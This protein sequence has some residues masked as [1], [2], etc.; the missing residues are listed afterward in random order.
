[1]ADIGTTF[2]A[3]FTDPVS[4][5]IG[6]TPAQP[7]SVPE[8]SPKIDVKTSPAPVAEPSP[9]FK[10]NQISEDAK[11]GIS[12]LGQKYLKTVDPYMKDIAAGIKAESDIALQKESTLAEA[13]RLK[14]QTAAEAYKKE[15]QTIRESKEYNDYDKVINELQ[16]QEF[17][18]TKENAQ[19][20]AQLFTFISLVGFGIG[21][22][23]KGSAQAAMSA[24]SGMMEGHMKGR[25]D[26]YKREKDIFETNIKLLKDK[27]EYIDKKLK[28]IIELAATDRMAA[29][30]M[31]DELFYETQATFYKDIK[32][33][34]GLIAVGKISEKNVELINKGFELSLK[35]FEVTQRVKE[36]L[37]M[38]GIKQELELGPFLREFSRQYPQGTLQRLYGASKEDKDRIYNS[39]QQITQTEEVAK[40]IMDNP[41][42]VSALAT[43]KNFINLDA[44]RS[45]KDN[46][47]ELADEKSALVD[48][49]LDSAVS[50]GKLSKDDAQTAKVL[51]KKLFALA[52]S[53]VRGSGQRGSIYLDKQFQK[54][55]D[56]ASRPKTLIDILGQR[57]HENNNNLAAYQLGIENNI[58]KA[59]YPLFTEGAAQYYKNRA[60]QP[61]QEVIDFFTKNPNKTSVKIKNTDIVYV[62]EGNKIYEE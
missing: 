59:N 58:Y 31:A 8:P 28:K 61:P 21:A 15:A 14:S 47:Y 48:Q 16:K 26:L 12:D 45:L 44:I 43:A 2:N 35:Q 5:F 46:E 17:V 27:A 49:Q 3:P 52:L 6:N 60:P 41:K 20:L 53:D 32:D 37:A 62:R 40:Y 39:S 54:I 19:D 22:G 36:Q 30:R 24:M 7:T 29:E 10:I 11:R 38:L 56:Q 42:A 33:K 23:G 18:P 4:S 1:M 51:Q 13:N 9:E 57:E 34:Q 50:S 55:Y 25:D